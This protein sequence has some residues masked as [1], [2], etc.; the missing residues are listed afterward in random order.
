MRYLRFVGLCCVWALVSCTTVTEREN[1]DHSHDVDK[2]LR[3]ARINTQLAMAY[4]ERHDISRAK[5]K[6][7]LAM[8]EGPSLPEVWYTMAYFLEVT[9]NK[10]K[11]QEHYLKAI[12]LA[13]QRG[14]ARNNYGT[15]LCRSGKIESAI[16]QFKLALQDPTY[17]DPAA[18]YEN[19]GLCALKIPDSVQAKFFFEK[20]LMENPRRPS[21]LMAL[22]KL[23]YKSGDYRLARRMLD[24][25]YRVNEAPT[26]QADLLKEKIY[27][28]L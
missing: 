14:D 1:V 9:G 20:A 28:K 25:F 23:N 2:Q 22:A 13:P 7:V 18:A 8:S 27:A 11:A 3:A 10:G 26:P 15:F 16:A 21:V 6:L 17:L 4:L 12:S 24:M 5:Q 19:A